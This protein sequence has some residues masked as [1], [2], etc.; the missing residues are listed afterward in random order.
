MTLWICGVSS[1]WRRQLKAREL[2]E[3]TMDLA[4]FQNVDMAT[5]RSI[6]LGHEPHPD[7]ME[8]AF[9]RVRAAWQ[10]LRRAVWDTLAAL[11][12]RKR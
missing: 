6:V 7:S 9:E 2:L 4:K 12:G 8:S 1:G 5:A 11:V 10:D 3:M